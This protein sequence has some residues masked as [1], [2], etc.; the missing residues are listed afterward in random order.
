MSTEKRRL[1]AIVFT[2]I[3]GFKELM[4]RDENKAMAL[5]EQQRAFFIPILINNY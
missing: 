2:D 4:S 5:L 3:C 1:A